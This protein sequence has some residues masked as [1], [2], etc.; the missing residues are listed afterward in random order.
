MDCACD[1][2]GLCKPGF[3]PDHGIG[4]SNLRSYQW[5]I[6]LP[7]INATIPRIAPGA[8][9]RLDASQL[10]ITTSSPKSPTIRI[11]TSMNR[12]ARLRTRPL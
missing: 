1:V 3:R 9:T 11:G 4:P 5:K 2:H 6:T 12:R 7:A 10:T 8:Q